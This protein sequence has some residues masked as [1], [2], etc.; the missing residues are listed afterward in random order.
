MTVHRLCEMFELD[1]SRP[2]Q[3][4]VG[5]VRVAAVRVGTEIFAVED[6]CSHERSVALG[7]GDV[8]PTDCTIECAKHGSLFSLRT[9]R[10][11]CLPATEDVA[12]FPTT[13]DTS[14]VVSAT[15][16]EA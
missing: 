5:G 3:V 11:M 12:T 6:R 16:P 1:E 7:D 15:L 8:D 4:T 13:I 9:G 2:I 10:V 14:G